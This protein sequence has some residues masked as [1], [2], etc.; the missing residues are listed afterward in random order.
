[1]LGHAA[2][3]EGSFR[4]VFFCSFSYRDEFFVGVLLICRENY[5]CTV[6]MTTKHCE[7]DIRGVDRRVGL[8]S[9]AGIHNCLVETRRTICGVLSMSKVLGCV[10]VVVGPRLRRTM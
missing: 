5:C 2:F 10:V 4:N 6:D 8:Y 9:S 3:S 7:K 1:M